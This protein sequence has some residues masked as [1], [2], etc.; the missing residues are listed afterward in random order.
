MVATFAAATG[1]NRNRGGRFEVA[2]TKTIKVEHG[3][4]GLWYVGW[5]FTVAVAQLPV[6]KALLAL[7]IWPWYLGVALR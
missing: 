2:E 4:G 3:Y 7:L 5:L 1:A 6:G